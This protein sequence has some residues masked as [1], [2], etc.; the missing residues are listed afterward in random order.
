M[1]H[2]HF[3]CQSHYSKSKLVWYHDVK[4]LCFIGEA[5][6]GLKMSY[7]GVYDLFSLFLMN[8]AEVKISKKSPF[9]R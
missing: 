8:V 5:I 9:I 4:N 1:K 3:I 2:I 7:G 6:M